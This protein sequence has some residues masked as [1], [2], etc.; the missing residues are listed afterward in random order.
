MIH[1]AVM[2]PNSHQN[3]IA[4]NFMCTIFKEIDEQKWNVFMW[5]KMFALVV[6]RTL[7]LPGIDLIWGDFYRAF[8]NRSIVK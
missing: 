3:N 6:G 1:V 5:T 8:E 4:D 7:A 2:L